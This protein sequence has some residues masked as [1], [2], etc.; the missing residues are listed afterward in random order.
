MDKSTRQIIIY[1]IEPIFS[2]ADVF[3]IQQSA[4]QNNEL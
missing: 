3:L 1:S 4:I 2:T